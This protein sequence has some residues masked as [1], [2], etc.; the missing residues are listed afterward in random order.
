MIALLTDFGLQDTYVAAMKASILKI[1]PNAQILDIHHQIEPQNIAQAAFDLKLIYKD[2]PVGTIFVVVV[3]PGVGSQRK[4]LMLKTKDYCFIGPDNGVFSWIDELR[5]TCFQILEEHDNFAGKSKTFHG[6]DVF[7]PLAAYH[8]LG[9][10]EGLIKPLESP[11]IKLE[12]LAVHR[13]DNM[14][15]A[16]IVKSDHF[17]NLITTLHKSELNEEERVARIE[18]N[19]VVVP[20]QFVDNYDELAFGEIG[21][22]W[23]SDDY[24]ELSCKNASCLKQIDL[25]TPVQIN[26]FIK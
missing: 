15:S 4:G 9:Q 7:A 16:L 8:E 6:R 3:D 12:G 10:T 1:H 5:P 22:L 18:V 14:F 25:Q 23:G 24:F 13:Q 26:L 19:G 20:F 2:M 17:G 11:L 21:G